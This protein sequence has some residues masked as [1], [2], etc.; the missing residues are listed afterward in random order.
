[1][2]DLQGIA[3]YVKYLSSFCF[4]FSVPFFGKYGF[5]SHRFRKQSRSALI[6]LELAL[7]E[8]KMLSNI[9]SFRKLVLHNEPYNQLHPSTHQVR[10]CPTCQF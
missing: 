7:E 8:T 3:T 1:V 4:S 9:L 6:K 2:V 5:V 10:S